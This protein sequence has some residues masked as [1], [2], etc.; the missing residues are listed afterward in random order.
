MAG[1]EDEGEEDGDGDGDGGRDGASG[2][3]QGDKAVDGKRKPLPF[4]GKGGL[5]LL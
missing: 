5:P 1:D 3:E 4:I 2:N